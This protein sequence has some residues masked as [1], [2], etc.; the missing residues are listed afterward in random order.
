MVRTTV[1]LD[2]QRMKTIH[3]GKSGKGSEA[4]GFGK[5]AYSP[6]EWMR[7]LLVQMQTFRVFQE[8]M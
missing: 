3:Q 4:T 5:V 1:G 2:H 6:L 8:F 7:Q